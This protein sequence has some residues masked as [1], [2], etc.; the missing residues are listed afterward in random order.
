MNRFYPKE[1]AMGEQKYIRVRV[2]ITGR[3]QGVFFRMETQR[4]AND[5]G[6]SGWVKNRKDGAVE[7]VFEGE[8]KRVRSLIDW[9]RNGPPMAVVHEVKVK[10]ETHKGEYDRFDITY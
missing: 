9:C 6:V 5:F 8:E 2:V 1:E 3:V 7:G 4:A 10:E